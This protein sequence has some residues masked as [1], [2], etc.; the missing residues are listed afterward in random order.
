M[1]TNITTT[2]TT[3]VNLTT[4]T[5]ITMMKVTTTDTTIEDGIMV[6][7]T[8]IMSIT[9]QN[10]PIYI[11]IANYINFIDDIYRLMPTNKYTCC[12]LC[13]VLIY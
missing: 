5:H 13:G 7:E 6:T 2:D 8:T 12:N 4:I 1:V 10:F 9:T 3:I 11:V